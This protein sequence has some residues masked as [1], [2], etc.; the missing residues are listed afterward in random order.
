MARTIEKKADDAASRSANV[1]AADNKK[2]AAPGNKKAV[3]RPQMASKAPRGAVAPR[4]TQGGKSPYSLQQRGALLA[5]ARLAKPIS[6]L[7]QKDDKVARARRRKHHVLKEI[8]EQQKSTAHAIARAPFQRQVR[9]T[10]IDV[11]G[12]PFRWQESALDAI[13]TAAEALLTQL[14]GEANRQTYAQRQKML[15]RRTLIFTIQTAR[16]FGMSCID[17]GPLQAEVFDMGGGVKL[18]QIEGQQQIK[19]YKQARADANRKKPKAAA[20]AAAPAAPAADDGDDEQG[21][22]SEAGVEEIELASGVAAEGSE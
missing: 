18:Q 8:R 10:T 16:R 20:A 3:G 15:L 9:E 7:S 4:P 1:A 14:F 13:Q 19:A 6:R 11:A 2:A 12:K 17:S 22:F 21:E 5:A